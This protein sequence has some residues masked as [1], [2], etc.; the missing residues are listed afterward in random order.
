MAT[1]CGFV[2]WVDMTK[3]ALLLAAPCLV[4]AGCATTPPAA[5]DSPPP[6]DASPSAQTGTRILDE[7]ELVRLYNASEMTLQ[8]ISWDRRGSVS[9]LRGPDGWV[10]LSGA[11]SAAN[12]PG[13]VSLQGR[14]TEV[15]TGYFT[16][17][18]TIRITDTPDTGRRCEATKKWHF[19]VTQDRPYWRLRE[20]EWCDGLTDYIDIYH[21]RVS[22]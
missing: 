13:R 18:G 6:V 2:R 22:G 14:I 1:N 21:P 7:A 19:A 20:F 5:P 4:L 15:G 3:L 8:W 10:Y 12:G 11:Q 9:I 16:F 17:D